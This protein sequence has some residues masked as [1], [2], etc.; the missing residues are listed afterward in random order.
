MKTIHTNATLQ[1]WQEIVTL[2]N[3]L[4]KHIGF[5]IIRLKSGQSYSGFSNDREMTMIINRGP[6]KFSS[7]GKDWKDL[8]NRNSMFNG[9][10]TGIY[11][12]INEK[13]TITADKCDAEISAAYC[14]TDKPGE[15]FVIHP[16]EYDIVNITDEAANRTLHY[17][18]GQNV[19][20]RTH[21]IVMVEEFV[22]SGNWMGVPPHKHDTHQPPEETYMAELYFF[23]FDPPQGFGVQINYKDKNTQEAKLIHT[24]DVVLLPDGYHPFVTLAG[25]RAGF[26]AILVSDVGRS[27]VQSFDPDHSWQLAESKGAE[28]MRDKFK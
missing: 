14:K 21:R 6:V 27:V 18:F 25:Y 24:N 8:G 28:A 4:L 5:G 12:P 20:G 3:N 17:V 19:E 15:P 23:K 2:D 7:A 26:H 1:G 10:A 16:G 13:F 22:E 9:P 11:V